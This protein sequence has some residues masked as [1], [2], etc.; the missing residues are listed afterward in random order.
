MPLIILLFSL[1][2]PLAAYLEQLLLLHLY[3]HLIL[4]HPREIG[5]IYVCI[6][7]LLPIHL[8]TSE[9]RYRE[10]DAIERIP[11]VTFT[12]SATEKRDDRHCCCNACTEI[13]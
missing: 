6:G 7:S 5:D 3:L 10:R 4:L 12:S 8:S 13:R 9:W 2:H 11:Q 1:P